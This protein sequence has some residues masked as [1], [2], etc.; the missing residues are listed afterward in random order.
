M[1]SDIKIVYNPLKD[2]GNALW[3]NPSRESPGLGT[4]DIFPKVN[5]F[6]SMEWGI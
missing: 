4:K 2:A 3:S 6:C 5:M 1:F